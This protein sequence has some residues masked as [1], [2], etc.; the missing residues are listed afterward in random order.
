MTQLGAALTISQSLIDSG[1]QIFKLAAANNFI[2]GR[3]TKSVAAVC[4]YIACRIQ[5]DTNRVMLIDFSDVLQVSFVQVALIKT[6]L[7]YP[8]LNV[9]KLGHIYKDLIDELRIN[10][11]GFTIHP[12]NPEDLILRFAYR[13]EFGEDTMRVANEAVRIVQRMNRDW[14]TPGRRPAGIC[15]AALVLAARMN[16]YRRTVREMVYIVKVTE[17]TIGKRLEEFKETESSSLTVEEFR[18]IDLERSCDPPAF[19]EQKK[20]T[21]KGSKRKLVEVDDGDSSGEETLPADS[22]S[23]RQV[24]S[25]RRSMPPPSI[26]IDPSLLQTS[27]ASEAPSSPATQSPST[28]QLT[29]RSIRAS[30]LKSNTSPEADLTSLINPPTTYSSATALSRVLSSTPAESQIGP[31]LRAEPRAP[32]SDDPELSESE[33][34]SDPEVTNCILTITEIEIKERIWTHE[35]A[36]WLRGQQQKQLKLQM[37]EANGTTRTIIKRTRRRGRMGDMRAYREGDDD[38]N[39]PAAS[40]PAEAAMKM[41]KKRGY[42]KKINYDALKKLYEPSPPSTPKANTNHPTSSTSSTTAHSLES[43]RDSSRAPS[44]SGTSSIPAPSPAAKF[45]TAQPQPGPATKMVPQ[46]KPAILAV[47]INKNLPLSSETAAFSTPPPIKPQAL[48]VNP[49]TKFKAPPNTTPATINTTTTAA[50]TATAPFTSRPDED[51]EGG[52]PDFW[53]EGELERVQ[54]EIETRLDNDEEGDDDDDDADDDMVVDDIEEEY[55]GE[56]YG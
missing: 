10:G 50:A 52:D 40:T 26:P 2:Q 55:E 22:P 29:R 14:M 27:L 12:I 15:G 16:N 7:K 46:T 47:P 11:N 36:D 44:P 4:L 35:N 39:G 56:E 42:S 31:P 3:R 48:G 19:K 54:G 32:I 8:K 38:E 53:D 37:D 18:T 51:Y 41:L 20:R 5:K 21:K 28:K 33:F 6:V 30:T 23:K 17:S 1:M 45:T 43:S 13:L 25:D 24:L 9:F 49:P 34:A